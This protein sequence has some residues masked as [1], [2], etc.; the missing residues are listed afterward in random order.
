MSDNSNLIVSAL[1]KTA[2]ELA[3]SIDA[4][5]SWQEAIKTR[6]ARVKLYRNYERGDHRIDMT[7]QQKKMAR[8]PE[9][10]SGLNELCV[11]YCKVIVDKMAGRLFVNNIAIENGDDWLSELLAYNDFDAVQGEWWRGSIRDGD[12]FI[13]VDSDSLRW[14]SEPAY[15]G[16]DGMVVIFDTITSVP[17][18]ACKLWSAVDTADS[19]GGDSV[20]KVV[21]Y[22]PDYIS[23]WKGR[24]GTG[25][26][27]ADDKIQG[28]DDSFTNYEPFPLGKI[29][30]VQV[31]N[32]LDSYTNYGES[33]LRPAIP[34]QD[35]LNSTQYDKFVASKLSAF[36]IYWSIG[37]EIDN[38]GVVPGAVIN[39]VLKNSDGTIVTDPSDAQLEFLKSVKVGSFDVT[40]I[41]QYTN[42]IEKETQ[43]I[44]QVT[45][46][47]IYGVTAQGNLSG[48]ALKQLEIGLLGKVERFQHQNTDAVRELISLT[49]EMQI[50]F[51]NSSELPQPPSGGSISVMWK[52][53][54]I[55]DVNAR[56]Q[57]IAQMR[58]KMPGLFADSFYIKR[59]GTLLGMSQGDIEQEIENA[60]NQSTSFFESLVGAGGGV[61]VA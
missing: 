61:P 44:S 41:G 60:Q 38:D 27:S 9:D 26:V 4:G 17:V 8:L 20:M 34:L 7:T 1:E 14:V 46:T 42:Q 40:D 10:D 56:I 19:S 21:V 12:S 13:V 31:A 59:I 47:P 33:E 29:P 49:A 51:D 37:M 52:S 45:Q 36:K 48:E 32:Q 6:G 54:E 16:F 53:P 3:A 2:P 50:T 22:Q 5:D 39:L 57:T 30:V 25:E 24:E 15:D 18:W 58:E 11:N 23:Y 35:S 55:L 28:E 43:Q